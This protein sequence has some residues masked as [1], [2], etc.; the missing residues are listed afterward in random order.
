M[1]LTP[2]HDG[3]LDIAE[4]NAAGR[5]TKN[6]RNK[7][8]TWAYLLNRFATT[9]RTAETLA[10]YMA[11]KKSRQ[12]EIKDIGGYV[13]GYLE[14]GRRKK[15]SVL[16]RQLLTLDLDFARPGFWEDFTMLFDYSA[17]MYS[18]HKHKPDSPRLRLVIPIDRPV[19]SDEYEAIARK[20]A[21]SIDI[22]LFDP[23]TFQP[24]RLMYW[25]STSKDG[26][27][28]FEWQDGPWLCADDV[29][30]Q[31]RNWKDT[32][33]WPVS[34]KIG[35]VIKSG[36][37]VQGDP[38]EKPGIVGAFCRVHTIH[39]AIEKHL[40][41]VYEACDVEDR[42]TYLQGSTAAGLITYDDKFA[43]SHHGTD[44]AGGKLCNAFDLVRI[45]KF[46]LQDE[47]ARDGTPTNKLPSFA[48]MLDFASSLPT[49]RSLMAEERIESAN[50]DFAEGFDKEWIDYIEGANGEPENDAWREELEYDKKAGIL[51]SH[52]NIKLI[53]ENDKYLR[54]C[55]AFD[56]FKNRKVVVKNLPW[57]KVDEESMYLMDEDEQNLT[58]Y[59][60][61]VY[62]ILNRANAKDVLDTHVRSKGFHPV[63]EYLKGLRWDGVKRIDTL[64]IDYM[65]ADDTE[66]VRAISRKSLTAC[67]ARVMVP[68]IKFDYVLTLVGEEGKRKSSLINALGG[69]WFSDSFSFHL[70]SKGNQAYEQIQGCWLIEI[71][72]LGGLRKAES[73]AVKH[74]IAK[75]EDSWRGAFK[76]NVETCKRQCVF[77]A[78]T[79]DATPLK[80]NNGNRRWW[81]VTIN[82][83]AIKKDVFKDLNENEVGQV[84]AEAVEAW[85]A[86]EQLYLPEHIEEMARSVQR[87]HTEKDDRAGFIQAYLDEPIPKDWDSWLLPERRAYYRQDDAIGAAVAVETERRTVV[88]VAEI[89]CELFG[90]GM[91]DLTSVNTK[92][93]HQI[94]KTLPG[95]MLGKTQKRRGILY[96]KQMVYERVSLQKVE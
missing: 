90:M 61:T 3:E 22:E 78:G 5:N 30:A 91:R 77:F 26:V 24:E 52:A 84:W 96:G 50:Y 39:D 57:R 54:G 29:L 65:G 7:S 21:G 69:K 66:Y 14:K 76:H 28:E 80:E 15:G 10:E 36:M 32:S 85:K 27:Y 25:P 33:E 92:P 79:N 17:A 56:E 88:S 95:W 89:C 87:K 86:G 19:A 74:F 75:R 16:T 43:Y 49:V 58:I 4:S 13:G 20:V 70:L 8:V 68:G 31:Y 83:D 34:S 2:S 94:M 23:T 55:F 67:V 60:S 51:S 18:T 45:H 64:F 35:E 72:E 48:A 41:G 62:G 42:Y 46:G 6:W 53:L 47:T 59:L 38:L 71:G 12:D 82:P 1:N 93:I 37:A 81:L 63:R 40:E 73:E 44:P 9:H 11:A